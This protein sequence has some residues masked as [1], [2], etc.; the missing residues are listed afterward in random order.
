M[1][2]QSCTLPAKALSTGSG[3]RALPLRA[4]TSAADAGPATSEGDLRGDF[5]DA[6][7]GAGSEGQ[8]ARLYGFL[9]GPSRAAWRARAQRSVVDLPNEVDFADIPGLRYQPSV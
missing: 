3:T 6:E 4:E 7:A 8:V 9:R 1:S 5:I 2:G